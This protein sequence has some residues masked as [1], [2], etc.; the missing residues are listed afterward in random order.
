MMK[1]LPLIL[2]FFLLVFFFHGVLWH[3]E[4]NFLEAAAETVLMTLSEEN[5][6][7]HQ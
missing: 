5:G 4:T 2:A 7:H 1:W 6:L 3:M